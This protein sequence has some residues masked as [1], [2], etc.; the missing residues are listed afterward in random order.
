[1]QT[2]AIVL[3]QP[4]SAPTVTSDGVVLPADYLLGGVIA[5][6]AGGVMWLMKRELANTD[7]RTGRIEERQ[8]SQSAEVERLEDSIADLRATLPRDYVHRDDWVRV[9]ANLEAK[10]D[11]VHRRLDGFFK[12]R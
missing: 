5:I 7:R 1:M 9:S 8:E 4:P 3:A 11:A 10:L 6:V 2:R 12:E